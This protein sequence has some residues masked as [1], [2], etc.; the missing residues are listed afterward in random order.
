MAAISVSRPA[1]GA[2]E[3]R[4]SIEAMSTARKASAAIMTCRRFH[5]STYTPATGP[6]TRTGMA[7]AMRTP[8]PAAGAHVCPLAI[9]TDTHRTVV[10]SKTLST[11][12]EMAGPS[13]RRRQ[14]R[15]R[16]RP[17][18]GFA[19]CGLA[20]GFVIAVIVSVHGIANI[21]A[22]INGGTCG[23]RWQDELMAKSGEIRQVTSVGVL[24]ALA[25][26]VRLAILTTLMRDKPRVMSV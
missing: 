11:V 10:I 19:D 16:R 9:T 17:A 13:Q 18:D 20:D 25:D 7:A 8:L 6:I 24:K 5:R 22:Y 23:N 3:G 14:S 1:A 12:S 2:I 4:T 15:F 21:H 26:P